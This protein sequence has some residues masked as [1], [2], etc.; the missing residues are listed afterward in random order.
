[1]GKLSQL[2]SD[3]DGQT[4]TRALPSVPVQAW[5]SDS[6][7]DDDVE[8][9]RMIEFSARKEQRSAGRMTP[10]IAGNV[11]GTS[12]VQVDSPKTDVAPDDLPI[13]VKSLNQ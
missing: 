11:V 4:N 6:S 3:G 10:R 5:A 13:A 8:E 2:A 1:M 9:L 12:L 7:D